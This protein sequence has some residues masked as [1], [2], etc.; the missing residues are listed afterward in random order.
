MWVLGH[1]KGKQTLQEK[2]KSGGD[3]DK[4]KG[5]GFGFD[6]GQ[7]LLAWNLRFFDHAS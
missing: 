2:I 4:R 1:G 7:C 6:G 5:R 3:R